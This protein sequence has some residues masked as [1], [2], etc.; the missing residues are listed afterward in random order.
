MLYDTRIGNDYLQKLA[1]SPYTFQ[2]PQSSSYFIWAI[3][4]ESDEN[5]IFLK[6]II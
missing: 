2:I 3:Y 4:F 5:Q 1:L 6:K